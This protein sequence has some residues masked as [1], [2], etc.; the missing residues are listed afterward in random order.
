M[1]LTSVSKM[2]A[3]PPED[4]GCPP[5]CEATPADHDSG[6]GTPDWPTFEGY[7][8]YRDDAVH[9]TAAEEFTVRDEARRNALGVHLVQGPG[10][11]VPHIELL[12]EEEDEHPVHLE[13]ILAEARELADA[14]AGLL[15]A[16]R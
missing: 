7:T 6:D 8:H 4:Y 10:D 9:Y 5:W 11:A 2:A 12:N 15:R 14:L 3:F 16:A 13:L 1:T